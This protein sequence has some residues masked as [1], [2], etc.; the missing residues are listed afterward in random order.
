M[1]VGGEAKR[2]GVSVGGEAKREGVPVETKRSEK[3]VPMRS[4]EG[5]SVGGEAKPVEAGGR[6]V[7]RL[8]E[9]ARALTE[10]D[11]FAKLRN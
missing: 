11:L 6:A 4:E 5:V 1:S 8:V 9:R 2:E 10:N 7:G 3:G